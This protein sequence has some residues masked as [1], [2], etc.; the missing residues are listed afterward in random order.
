MPK[1]RRYHETWEHG[2]VR[3]GWNGDKV[4]VIRERRNG[5]R[6]EVSTKTAN[7]AMALLEYEE[8]DK[9]PN[10]YE[11]GR[12]VLREGDAVRFTTE[13]IE[14]FLEHGKKEGNEPH[15]TT[16]KSAAMYFWYDHFKDR[17]LRRIKLPD[18]AKAVRGKPQEGRRRSV[19][20]TFYRWLRNEEQPAERRISPADDPTED[21]HVPQYDENARE[22]EN[23][24]V[25]FEVIRKVRDQLWG[26]WR[27]LLTLGMA[28][29]WHVTE[30][31]RFAERGGMEP[32]KG[33][34]A[35]ATWT[36][37]VKHKGGQWHQTA[38]DA[39]AG[40]AAQRIKEHGRFSG[41]RYT[42]AIQKV[43]RD[44]GVDEFSAGQLRHSV[45][46]HLVDQGADL[47]AVSTFLGQRSPATARRF[48]A[49]HATPFNPALTVA[50][51]GGKK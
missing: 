21:L 2:F 14:E 9:N 1:A 19:L 30:L 34:Q 29:G 10:A 48:Y 25:P 28:T 11:P 5:K 27:D 18:L 26:H 33:P 42:N 36:L 3:F 7:H 24:A 16:N 4:Y 22:Q 20:K 6:Y 23:K 43:C 37:K 38:V 51:S 40:E 32:Y 49:T 44:L 46:T 12:V 47:A 15:T 50:Q 8:W 13:L 31:N 35:G 17:D 41:R 45:A 39:E